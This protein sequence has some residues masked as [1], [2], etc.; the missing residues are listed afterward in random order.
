MST[1]K[2]D[3]FDKTR[4]FIADRNGVAQSEAGALTTTDQ[5]PSKTPSE[6]PLKSCDTAPPPAETNVSQSVISPI[7]T[8]VQ[9]PALKLRQE[10]PAT[11]TIS[12]VP[13]TLDPT[14]AITPDQITSSRASPVTPDLSPVRSLSTSPLR[15]NSQPPIK[16]RLAS[17]ESFQRIMQPDLLTV[18]G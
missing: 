6:T 3:V 14:D 7:D 10:D 8:V 12:T 15:L 11:K 5:T 1:V 2:A 9:R 4:H 18:S 17:S 16:G 13:T